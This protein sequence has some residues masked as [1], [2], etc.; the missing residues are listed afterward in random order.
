[1]GGGS[2][3]REHRYAYGQFMLTYGKNHHNIIRW[4]QLKKKNSSFYLLIWHP[5]LLSSG[6]EYPSSYASQKP[7]WTHC[8]RWPVHPLSLL[9]DL[10]TLLLSAALPCRLVQAPPSLTQ[11]QLFQL[12]SSQ[13]SLL[14]TVPFSS[15][16][17][18]RSFENRSDHITPYSKFLFSK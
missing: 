11:K 18:K 10:I 12:C 7:L 9:N 8:P 5:P 15:L 6:H 3:E 2:G 14:L 1:M 17:P 13:L 4:L 16:P